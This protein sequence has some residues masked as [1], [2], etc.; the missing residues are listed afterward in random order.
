MRHAA[1]R[2]F[3]QQHGDQVFRR[4]VAKELA[5]MFLVESDAMLFDQADK[6]RYRLNQELRVGWDYKNDCPLL[7][8]RKG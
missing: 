2:A 1:G 6:V 5:F 8:S 3:G 7:K 4:S